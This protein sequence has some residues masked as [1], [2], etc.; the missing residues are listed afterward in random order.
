ME[1]LEKKEI[2]GRVDLV[3]V[4]HKCD[5]CNNEKLG[6]DHPDDWHYFSHQHGGWGND[7]IDSVEWFLVCSPECYF[8]QLKKSTKQMRSRPDQE[9]DNMSGD[10]V[11]KLVECI[12]HFKE[13]DW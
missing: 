7:N 3:V 5:I 2:S 11:K 8:K 1:I 6:K 4:G 13:W 10:F 9:I 12:D